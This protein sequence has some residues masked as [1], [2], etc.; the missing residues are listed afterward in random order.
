[1][2]PLLALHGFTG[3][4]G[5]WSFLAENG[6]TYRAPVLVGHAGASDADQV[7]SFEGEVDRLA[8]FARAGDP[9]HLV[10][11]SLGARLA[12]GIALRHPE[13]VARLTL[14]SVHPG[15]ASE[16]E[17]RVRRNADSVWVE[18]LL[19]RGMQAFVDAWEA[20]PMWASQITLSGTARALR[21]AAR[22]SHDAAGLAR[23]LRVTGL[24]EMPGYAERLAELRMPVTL[25][26]GD[27]DL[28]FSSLARSMTERIRHATIEL[29][30]GAGHDLLLEHP[31]LVSEVV[32]RGNQT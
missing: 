31:A 13:C 22:L 27:L 17:R 12:L 9:L 16:E 32:R 25:L 18:L 10:G 30:P 6:L 19:D 4:P 8:N 7:T 24:G 14:I 26:A 21:R 5:N 20:Q 23:S 3:S 15:L 1:V 28:K 11:Y 29:V 2:K